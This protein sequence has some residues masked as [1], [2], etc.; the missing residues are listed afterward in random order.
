MKR[1]WMIAA[2]MGLATVAALLFGG[3]ATDTMPALRPFANFEGGL[4]RVLPSSPIDDQWFTG[5]SSI[6]SATAAP[7]QPATVTTQLSMV[8]Y[9]GLVVRARYP[10]AQTLTTS[11]VVYIWGLKGSDWT[12]LP[13]VNGTQSLTLSSATTDCDDGATYK[14]T[15][16]SNKVDALGATWITVTVATAA[17]ASSGGAV[18][19]E[20]TRF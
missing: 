3:V 13:D 10:R 4:L 8:G 2:G 14:W 11:P 9:T 16:P 5:V 7:Y 12:A 20:V 17:V 15:L 19:L 1:S 6:T 18:A